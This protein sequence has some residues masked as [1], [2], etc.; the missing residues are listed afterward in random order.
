M[1][2]VCI[3][4]ASG[5]MGRNI[6]KLVFED[7][8]TNL[9]GAV[10]R[11]ESSIYGKPI[12]E[13]AG[14]S[15]GGVVVSDDIMA[16]LQCSDVVID[17][18]AAKATVANITYY[19]KAGIPLVIGSTGFDSKEK[20][21]LESLAAKIPVLLAPNMSLGVNA[22]LK[23]IELAAAA[24]QG[25]DIEI[26][27]THHRMKKDAPSGT[28]LA[29][30]EAA[31]KGAGL[32]LEESAVYCRQGIIGERKDNEIGIQSLRGGDVVGDHTV[33]FFGNGERLEI[34]HRAH[35]R[36]VFA[37]GAVRAAKWMAKYGKAGKI[38]SMNDVLGI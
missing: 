15:K 25:Y 31:A 20:K 18:T 7:K 13:A 5:R 28:A 34:T 11:F 12:Y 33:F 23:L 21:N 10:D 26:S 36:E 32:N 8:E 35:T 6:A 2:N 3:I 37:Q 16:G 38:Y 1:I 24:L 9:S 22:A 4:G 19:K 17:F 14:I 27:E 29:M 30:A